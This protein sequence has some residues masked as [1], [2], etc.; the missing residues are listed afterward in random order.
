MAVFGEREVFG[1]EAFD[2]ASLIAHD[3]GFYDEQVLVKAVEIVIELAAAAAGSRGV[4]RRAAGQRQK[5]I[6]MYPALGTS[7][8]Q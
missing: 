8:P 6:E 1:D 5:L 7:S 2:A 3:D 4:R